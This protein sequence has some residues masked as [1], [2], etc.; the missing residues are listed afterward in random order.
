MKKRIYILA[1]LLVLMFTLTIV[2]A[3]TRVGTVEQI[4]SGALDSNGNFSVTL[5]STDSTTNTALTNT[6]SRPA[7]LTHQTSGTPATGIGV[8]AS[9]VQETSA[10][11]NE[12]VMQL[13]AVID[14]A[15]ATSE[16]AS[17]SVKL[18][19]AGAAAAEKFAIE[20][21]GVVTLVNGETIDNSTDGTILLTSPVVEVSAALKLEFETSDP[22]GTFP[23]GTIFYND[24][25]NIVCFC[26]QAGDDLKVADGAACF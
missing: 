19:A 11:N 6:V 16:D 24:T 4:L 18:M 3:E 23:E 12:T 20:S 8:G 22:C 5:S 7:T 9:F 17:F 2:A 1:S 15:T 14:D 13:D 25:A 10:A 26:D 21:T